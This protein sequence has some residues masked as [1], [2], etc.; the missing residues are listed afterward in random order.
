MEREA[1]PARLRGTWERDPGHFPLPLSPSFASLYLPWQDAGLTAMFREFGY[2]AGRARS[3]LVDGHL[4]VQ[5]APA[6]G[7]VPPDWLAPLA[8]RLWWLYPP[9][10]ARVR[11]SVRC[12]RTGYAERMIERWY[13][14]WRPQV[15]R[16][17]AAAAAA[18]LSAVDDRELLRHFEAVCRLAGRNVTLHFRLH[19][20]IAPAIERLEELCRTLPELR[21]V[22]AAELVAGL[23]TESSAPGRALRRLAAW[24]RAHP[25][26]L[27]QAR[28]LGAEAVAA[29]PERLDLDFARRL[30]AWV[31]AYGHRV[32]GRYDFVLPT[33]AE[34]PARV[35]EQLLTL[36]AAP[37]EGAPEDRVARRREAAVA[38][39]RERLT[40]TDRAEFEAALHTAQ[41]AYPVRDDNVVLTFN[42]S[43]AVVRYA[44]LEIGR[45]WQGRALVQR[46]DVF[47]LTAEEIRH[48]LRHGSEVDGGVLGLHAAARRRVWERQMAAPPPPLRFGPPLRVP[49]LDGLPREAAFM[50]RAVVAYLRGIQALPEDK[51]ES[52]P[53]ARVVQGIPAVAGR[54]RGVARVIRDEAEFDRLGAGEVLVCPVTSPAWSTLFER[55]GALVTDHGGVLSHP[56]VLAREYG[57]PAV[58]ATRDGTRRIPDGA[59]VLVDGTAGI[60]TVETAE[61]NTAGAAG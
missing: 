25:A 11:R 33:P 27:D 61:P 54:Y 3:V 29:T 19:G 31:A 5:V 8:M 32:V 7:W 20:A 58:V 12:L 4:Y 22:R 49:P 15:E 39:A 23:S 53:H 40:G 10:A 50:T 51:A 37:E 55:A 9:A 13:G 36:A 2:L 30:R 26:L 6:G 45:R 38:A 14:E 47:F 48:G 16:E 18:D 43:F 57:I 56:A 28:I 42:G 35:V 1:N 21:G 52:A 34:Q 46:D 59:I 41:R 44:L 17:L 60:V 24:L